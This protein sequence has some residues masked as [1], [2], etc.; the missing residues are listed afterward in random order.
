MVG[1]MSKCDKMI[2]WRLN[3]ENTAEYFYWARVYDRASLKE[4]WYDFL[5]ENL[6]KV[7]TT[8]GWKN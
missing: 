1:R 6:Q 7:E 2:I 3:V 8:D 4:A 5:T